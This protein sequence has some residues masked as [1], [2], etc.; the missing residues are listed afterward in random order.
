M[1]ATNKIQLVV[2]D[3]AGTTVDFGSQAPAAAFRAVFSA[4]G[5][6][7]SPEEARAPMGLNK[8]EHLLAMLSN[9]AVAARWHSVHQRSWTE[10]DVHTMYHEFMPLQLRTIQ[11][12]CELVPNLLGVVSNLQQRGVKIGAT[13]GYFAE[14]ANMVA[15]EAARSGFEPEVNVC[16]DD[17]PQ[18]R[19]AP[20]MIYRVMERCGVYPPA[21]VINVGDTIADIQAGI[22]AGCWSVGVCDSSSLTGISA[23]ELAVLNETDRGAILRRTA[24]TFHQAGCHAVVETISDLPMLLDDIEAKARLGPGLTPRM[25][26][27]ESGIRTAVK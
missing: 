6:E 22:A 24:D 3:W 5:V 16:A 14:A 2:F 11:Q 12:N 20:W 9:P 1:I 27:G 23:T 17:V 4:H 19:P 13:T 10:D 7:V 8:R 15:A 26:A 25:L 21:A 18:G